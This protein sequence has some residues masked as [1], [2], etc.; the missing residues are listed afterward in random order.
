MTRLMVLL[1][2]WFLS[3]TASWAQF[4]QPASSTSTAPYPPVLLTTYVYQQPRPLR[5]WSVRIDLT[6]PDIEFVVTPP[7]PVDPGWDTRSQT[8]LDFAKEQQV[9]LAINASPFEPLRQKGGEPMH[10]VGLHLTRGL[11]LANQRL[12]EDM[13]A[14]L[15]DGENRVKLLN[16]PLAAGDLAKARH[17][18]GGFSMV[19]LDGKP[20]L[21][22][23]RS[24]LPAKHPRT[25][26]GLSEKGRYLWWL[27]V[28][29]RQEGKSEGLTYKELGEWGASLG[30]TDLLNLDGGGSTTLVLQ[31]PKSKGYEVMNT[32]VG[33]GPPGSLRFNGN[34]LG[35]RLYTEPHDLT[36]KQL[37][38]IMPHLPVAKA[39]LFLGP[40]NRT[41]TEH[42]INTPL[43]RA[44]FLAQLAHESGELRY[45]EEIASGEA[46]E[47]R[48]SLG[49]TEPGDGKRYKGRGP[50]QLTG[51]Y[52]YRQ[53][54]KDMGLDLEEHPEKA[55]DPETGC[56]IAGW[57]W[58]TRKLNALA[59]AGDFTA[60]TRKIN[61]GLNGQAQRLLYYRKA[62][63]VFSVK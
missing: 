16:Y 22:Q 49:N 12:N 32:P 62:K 23:E 53:A 6:H 25:A 31:D 27:I 41:M 8:T 42:E 14:M 28:D 24:A 20:M 30:I 38:A 7:A 59:D 61:G 58:N 48:A 63:D 1:A 45:M 46:Y 18:L 55:T 43:R 21:S 57:F 33:K 4:P 51:R 17:G 15:I 56:R 50:I 37:Q 44:A 60:I 5:A 26:V 40:L 34:N 54:G 10:I 52:N 11:Q 35:L 2:C 47:G 19:L 3:V 9:Q 13:G 29:G 39:K 36:L